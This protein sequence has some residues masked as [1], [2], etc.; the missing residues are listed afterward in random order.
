MWFGNY[1][2]GIKCLQ[3]FPFPIPNCQKDPYI[4]F[5]EGIYAMCMYF[6]TDMKPS[7]LSVTYHIYG[8]KN[9]VRYHNLQKTGPIL[10]MQ[11]HCQ[12][13]PCQKYKDLHQQ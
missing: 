7:E 13:N 5:P 6:L 11:P 9:G 10:S 4:K 1:W 8:T 2:V 3:V 12:S